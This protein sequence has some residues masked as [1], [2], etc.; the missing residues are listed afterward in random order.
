[1]HSGHLGL[2]GVPAVPLVVVDSEFIL[3]SVSME[4]KENM[5]VKGLMKKRN[6]ATHK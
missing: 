5:D 3:V 6:R 1:M 4:K 2:L